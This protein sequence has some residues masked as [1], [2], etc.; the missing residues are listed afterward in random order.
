VPADAPILTFTTA[1]RSDLKPGAK[2][3]V[4]A[5]KVSDGVYNALRITVGKTASTRRNSGS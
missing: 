5:N 4:N 1:A 2:V 3:L